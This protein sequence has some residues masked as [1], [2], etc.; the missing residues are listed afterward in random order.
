MGDRTTVYLRVLNS[1]S[2]EAQKHFTNETSEDALDDITT[3]FI[4]EEVNYGELPFLEALRK[5]GIAYDS[6]WSRGDEYDPGTESLRFDA[7]GKPFTSTVYESDINPNL[8]ALIALINKPD[9]LRAYLLKHQKKVADPPW[10]NQEEYGKLY[11]VKQL[12]NPDLT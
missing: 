9:E 3:E 4:F 5:A 6:S 1:Q 11:Q 12:I 10:D 7:E 8:G 2:V